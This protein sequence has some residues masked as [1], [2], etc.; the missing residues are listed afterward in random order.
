[1]CRVREKSERVDNFSERWGHGAA[2]WQSGED[3]RS[4]GAG[5]VRAKV[6]T[7]WVRRTRR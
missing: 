7:G 5:E 3:G 2:A 6:W 1:M 4:G